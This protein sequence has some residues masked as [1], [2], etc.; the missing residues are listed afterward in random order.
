MTRE[1]LTVRTATAADIEGVDILLA[2]SYPAILKADYRPSVLVTAIP[3][4]SKVQPRLVTC[5]TYYVAVD[6]EGTIVGAGGWT[7]S[8]P[9]GAGSSAKGIGHVRH[10]VSDHRRLREGIGRHLMARIF[11]TSAAAGVQQL[12][13]FS[14]LTA[15]PFY[16]ACGFSTLGP[17][18]VRL[19]EGI[20]FPAV[21]MRRFAELQ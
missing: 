4:I 3:L 19:R 5:G 7:R 2:R 10:V 11:E 1:H 12:E 15:V 18:T 8:G 20:D 16:A 6:P 9:P 13:C 14:T 17:M 21:H